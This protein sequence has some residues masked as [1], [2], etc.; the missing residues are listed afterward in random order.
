MV[1][2]QGA[3]PYVAL[4]EH[5]DAR[6]GEM[7]EFLRSLALA[8]SPSD[9]P[10][11]QSEVLGIL[12]ESLRSL[13]YDVRRIAGRSSG[14]HLY[15]R[16]RVRE[17][18]R[19]GQLLVG[20]CDTVW[21]LGTLRQMPFE[22]ENGVIR[23]PGVFDMKGGLTQIVFAL[24][25]LRELGIEPSFTPVVFVN[26]DEE[27]GSPES[28]PWVRLLARN[29]A[30]ALVLEPAMGPTGRIKTARK[31]VGA[32]EVVAMGKAAHAGLDPEGGASAV[33]EISHIIQK[34]YGLADPELGITVNV[35]VVEGG[36]R[37]NVVAPEARVIVDAR[38]R[39]LADAR[40]IDA[41]IRGLE[42]E[43]PG[44]SL[45]VDGEFR[46]PP[47]ERTPRNRGLWATAQEVARGLGLSIEE[48]AAGGGSDGNTTSQYTATLD[49]LGPVGGGAH[50]RHE[51]VL[52]DGLIERTALLVGLVMAPPGRTGSEA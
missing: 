52:I 8:E 12:T 16:P 27:L 38:V 25:T 14:G 22:V 43:D 36:L 34:L 41:A 10:E 5:V 15:A 30:R 18:G 17:R 49:G 13:D 2:S 42:A 19:P 32:F 3:S 24:R 20:H 45:R 21:P 51:F 26:S 4:L 1:G 35:G 11:S 33:L 46:A 47:M 29:V 39:T 50:A 28:R 37:S 40:R 9:V 44:V 23:G 7:I 48:V 6:R 31:G